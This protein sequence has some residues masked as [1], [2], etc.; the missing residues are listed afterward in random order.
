MSEDTAAPPPPR[1]DPWA[2]T[3]PREALRDN[4][5]GRIVSMTPGMTQGPGGAYPANMVDF[6]GH[7]ENYV[8]DVRFTGQKAM[9][10]RSATQ[11]VHNGGSGGI[12][13]PIGHAP[14]VRAGGSPVIRH[15]DAFW[16]DNRKTVGEAQFVRDTA[17]YPPPKDIDPIAGSLQMV[18][19]DAVFRSSGSSAAG[20]ST[21]NLLQNV[22]SPSSGSGALQFSAPPG[23]QAPPAAPPQTTATPG[24]ANGGSSNGSG[25]SQQPSP[26]ARVRMG[27]MATV[28]EPFCRSGSG[29]QDARRS[30]RKQHQPKG[31]P[32]SADWQLGKRSA[33]P[34]ANG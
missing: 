15:G 28:A 7:D 22:R 14:Q 13:E 33:A 30:D 12:C 26:R 25:S 16:M 5:A 20:T 3:D 9:V 27:A 34:D 4:N 11:H 2:T 8:P 29:A 31:D 21:S 1:P 6:C 32:K 24:A 10:L 19:S 18:M 23:Q 17:T